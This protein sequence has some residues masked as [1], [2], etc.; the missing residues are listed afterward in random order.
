MSIR[1]G[2]PAVSNTHLEIAALVR[3]KGLAAFAIT[4]TARSS[5]HRRRTFLCSSAHAAM[6]EGVRMFKGIEASSYCRGDIDLPVV[7]GYSFEV[8]LAGFTI[9][10]ISS[11]SRHG[12]N[13]RLW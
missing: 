9:M 13:T 1:S 5:P 3:K 10:M 6:I 2:A 11:E 12:E 4:T 8:I 7:K